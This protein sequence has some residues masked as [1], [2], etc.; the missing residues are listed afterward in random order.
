MFC[1]GGARRIRT[2]TTARRTA[3]RGTVRRH[4]LIAHILS[5]GSIAG[6]VE[7]DSMPHNLIW[8]GTGGARV[9]TSGGEKFGTPTQFL[10]LST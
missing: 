8:L 5:D 3:Q 9:E 4:T 2:G 10:Q 7:V 1:V 6:A